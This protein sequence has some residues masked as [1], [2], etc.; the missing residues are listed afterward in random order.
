[1]NDMTAETFRLV[2]EAWR[3]GLAPEPQMTVSEWAD[4]FRVLPPESAEPGPWR[5]SRLPYLKEI[6]DCLSIASPIER[7]VVMKGAQTGGTEAGLNSVGYWMHAAPGS[8]MI[9]WPSLSLVRRN[10]RTRIDPLIA[11]TPALRAKVAPRRARDS[12]NTIDTKLFNGGQLLMVGANAAADLRSTAVR[13]LFLDEVDAF[14]SDVEDE[15]DPVALAIQRTV[16]YR[17]RRK[18]LMVSTPTIAGVSRIEKAYAET[19]QRKFFLPCPHCSGFQVLTWA[20]IQWPDSE[21]RKAVCA[22]EFCGVVIEERDKPAM[23][24]AGEWRATA[25]GDGRS[26]GFHLPSLL[27]AFEPWGEIAADFL[28]AKNDPVRLKSWVNLKLGEAYEDRDTAPVA[29]DVL[30]ARSEAFG[31]ELPAGVGVITAGVDTQDDR[32]EVEFVGWGRGEESW[33][34]GYEIIH[35]DPAKPEPWEALDKLLLRRWRHSKAVPDMHVAAVAIDSGGH[36]T[37]QVI[38]FSAARL[39]RRVWAI[40]GRGGA[41]IPPW[42]RRPPKPKRMGLAPVHVIGVDGIKSVLMSRLRLED[43]DGPGVAHFPDDR[44]H[45]WFAGLLAERA[46]RKW[47][48]GVARIEWIPDPAVR[49]EPLDCRVYATAALSGLAAAGFSLVDA[50]KFVLEAPE[51]SEGIAAGTAKP[52]M[53]RIKSAWLN[54]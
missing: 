7:V 14:P 11:L 16:S 45:D 46:V 38:A 15:G 36:R 50:A 2:D 34:L 51:R 19:D 43:T 6:Q 48:R 12:D 25:P 10:S 39:N 28:A 8:I 35:G 5:T 32:I 52:P 33:S 37:G 4:R 41:D 29:A 1:M 44:A 31:G 9:V 3:R 26:A 20:H 53:A 21:P 18:I 47:R 49:N 30:A 27:S 22:C 13:Y 42:P 40:K 24:A 17:G 54:R 23:L